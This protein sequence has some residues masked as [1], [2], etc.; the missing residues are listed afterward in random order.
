MIEHHA[1]LNR[2]DI[3]K[4]ETHT[5]KLFEWAPD[6]LQCSWEDQGRAAERI[7]GS[8]QK[9][10]LPLHTAKDCEFLVCSCKHLSEFQPAS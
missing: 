3:S 10:D 7:Y 2:I 4:V 9:H 1:Q 8:H 6:V 5:T